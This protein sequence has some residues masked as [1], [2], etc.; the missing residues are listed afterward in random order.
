MPAGVMWSSH[1]AY[2][3]GGNWSRFAHLSQRLRSTALSTGCSGRSSCTDG[4]E[5]ILAAE[6]ARE[7]LLYFDCDAKARGLFDAQAL[8]SRGYEL[9][10]AG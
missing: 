1:W 9:N 6:K 5:P 7:V 2:N 10:A 3:N 4:A 8:K